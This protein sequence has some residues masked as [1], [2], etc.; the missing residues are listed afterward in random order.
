MSHLPSQLKR[1][2]CKRLCMC[3]ALVMQPS[4]REA[5]ACAQPELSETACHAIASAAHWKKIH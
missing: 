3:P 2:L 1:W 4:M 5:Q